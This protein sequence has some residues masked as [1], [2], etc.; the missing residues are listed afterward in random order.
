[1]GKNIDKQRCTGENPR[2]PDC[3]FSSRTNAFMEDVEGHC[4]AEGLC[5]AN[6]CFR[7][8]HCGAMF[9]PGD[10]YLG[11]GFG[12]GDV[13]LSLRFSGVFVV[14]V[15]VHGAHEILRFF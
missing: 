11:V 3:G 7:D 2:F 9:D 12:P 15:G 10:Y 13:S 14:V 8:G 6:M 4:D 5:G 1:M